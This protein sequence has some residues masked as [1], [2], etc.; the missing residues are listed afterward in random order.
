MK[1]LAFFLIAFS[2]IF[3]CTKESL[4][5]SEN[6]DVNKP[7]I[8]YT[9]NEIISAYS[10]EKFDI[11]IS[12]GSANKTNT[13][14]S[15]IDA[16]FTP[17]AYGFESLNKSSAGYSLSSYSFSP[18]GKEIKLNIVSPQE[19]N[20]SSN[21]KSINFSS[22]SESRRVLVRIDGF[23]DDVGEFIGD[24]YKATNS[25]NAESMSI[26]VS[27][28]SEQPGILRLNV[29][30]KESS[31]S[32]EASSSKEINIVVNPLE[33]ENVDLK[34]EKGWSIDSE[35][36]EGYIL[37]GEWVRGL[38]RYVYFSFDKESHED[39]QQ[40]VVNIYSTTDDELR[41]ELIHTMT[42]DRT[43]PRQPWTTRLNGTFIVEF[44]GKSSI[45]GDKSLISS[46]K[47]TIPNVFPFLYSHSFDCIPDTLYCGREYI[48]DL[49]E[50][51]DLDGEIEKFVFNFGKLNRELLEKFVRDYSLVGKK[52]YYRKHDERRRGDECADVFRITFSDEDF[53][54]ELPDD[55]TSYTTEFMV[56]ADDGE[57]KK[58]DLNKEEGNSFLKRT[59]TL[60]KVKEP[61]ATFDMF[62]VNNSNEVVNVNGGKQN[63]GALIT[64]DASHCYSARSFASFEAFINLK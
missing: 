22:S 17:Y 43:F 62:V 58:E 61:V 37:P 5:E 30:A 32:E 26:P 28:L 15:T 18:I 19:F 40:V 1:K 63:I 36:E 7:V 33:I 54:E 55:S 56:W 34:I 9:A 13:L 12:K 25:E 44:Y 48:F 42:I 49:S 35:E 10:S 3:S 47:L 31:D 16:Y 29:S 4:T 41:K 2:F 11:D 46:S 24:S 23:T 14:E 21:I 51:V 27:I 20:D 60:K 45:N 6:T 53:P 50:T 59:V 57:A 38:G 39:L 64:F 52:G 8:S